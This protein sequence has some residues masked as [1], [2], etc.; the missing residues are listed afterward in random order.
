MR[1]ESLYRVRLG[2]TLIEMMVVILLLGLLA[3]MVAVNAWK[4]FDPAVKTTVLSEMRAIRN[5]AELYKLNH[6]GRY[7]SSLDELLNEKP[8]W[9]TEGANDPWGRPYALKLE[10][11]GVIVL[12]YGAD[13]LP[14]GENENTDYV[15]PE[16]K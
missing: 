4:V 1:R 15:Y 8:P 9:L 10:R 6:V 7:P 5:A 2:F 16:V 14:G 12:C 13:G 11:D 3:G